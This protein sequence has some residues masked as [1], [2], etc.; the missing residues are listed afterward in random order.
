LNCLLNIA[1]HPIP[2]YGPGHIVNF[3]EDKLMVSASE[4]IAMQQ[5]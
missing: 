1:E 3:R 4:K 2:G 5:A